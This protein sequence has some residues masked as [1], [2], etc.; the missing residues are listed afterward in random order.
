MLVRLSIF[1]FHILTGKMH[2]LKYDKTHF[3][4][5]TNCYMLRQESVI[6]RKFINNK[7]S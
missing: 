7:E 6:F 2:Q 4:L 1:T 5:D 3:I